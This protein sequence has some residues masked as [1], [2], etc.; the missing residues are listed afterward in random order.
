MFETARAAEA[1]RIAADLKIG[2]V[3]AAAMA[4]DEQTAFDAIEDLVTEQGRTD[5]DTKDLLARAA[6]AIAAGNDTDA[7][8]LGRQAAVNLLESKGSWTCSAAEYALSGTDGDILAWL[9]ADRSLAVDQDN[10][11]SILFAAQLGSADLADAAQAVLAQDDADAVTTF[12]TT[13][14]HDVQA[15]SYRVAILKLMDGAGSAVTAAANDALDDGGVDALSAFIFSGYR[16]AQLEDD[17]VATLAI[18][19]VGGANVQAAAQ[20]AMAGT[21]WMRRDFV[22]TVQHKAA[23]LDEDSAAHIAAML[24]AIANAARVAALAQQNAANASQAAALARQA[25]AEA[26]DWAT[27]AKASSDAAKASAQEALDQ[28]N[29]ADASAASAAAS[30]NK[31]SAAAATARGAARRAN[32]SAN[33]AVSSASA[34][35]ASA[36]SARTSAAS[37]RASAIQA[38]KDKVAAAAEASAANSAVAAKRREE[39][40]AAAAAAAAQARKNEA[41]GTDPADSSGNDGVDAPGD[42]DEVGEEYSEEEYYEGMANDWDKVAVATG[43]IGA[44]SLA[45]P[46]VGEVVAPILG[47]VSLVAAG[48]AA[49]YTYRAYGVTSPEFGEALGHVALDLIGGGVAGAVEASGVES[50]AATAVRVGS[51]A[52]SKVVGIFTTDWSDVDWTPW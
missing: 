41:D 23:Q 24:A 5:T 37:A 33:Q 31:A 50:A 16:T 4:D 43:L 20:T 51:E 25:A 45:I 10:R 9:D 3:E 15:E 22:T 8:T 11:E 48:I 26:A 34:A 42:P 30:A 13:G 36:A 19:N 17:R 1:A 32:Y 28:A 49:Y 52:A 35:L 38:G 2:L 40:A 18:M 6:D 14:I 7:A 46:V 39:Q 21:A 44:G 12:L 27:K 47:G 29:A